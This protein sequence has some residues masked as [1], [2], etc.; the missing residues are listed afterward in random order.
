[1]SRLL[2]WVLPLGPWKRGSGYPFLLDTIRWL[3][4]PQWAN[5]AEAYEIDSMAYIVESMDAWRP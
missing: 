1:V 3:W 5:M 2:N 4:F